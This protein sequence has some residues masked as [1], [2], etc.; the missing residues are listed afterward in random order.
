MPQTPP[1]KLRAWATWPSTISAQLPMRSRPWPRRIPPTP[2]RLVPSVTGNARNSTF[3]SGTSCS[4]IRLDAMR[5][6]GPL[7]RTDHATGAV[8]GS[9]LEEAES[10]SDELSAELE[11]AA[12]TRVGVD[13]QLTVRQAS[14]QVGRVV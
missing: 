10:G 7:S 3:R 14:S 4:T 11:D 13:L 6:A 12:V 9:A 5:S 2:A 1:A 8:R